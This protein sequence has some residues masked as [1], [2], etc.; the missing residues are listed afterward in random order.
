M[1]FPPTALQPPVGQGLLIIQA[2]RSHSDTPHSVVLLWTSDQPVAETSLPDDT[3]HSQEADIHA[4]SGVRI[5]N[6]IK[7]T[8]A[9]PRLRGRSHWDAYLV[10]LI[11]AKQLIKMP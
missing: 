9:D 2:S 10:S 11:K 7:P 4:P 1:F 8:A 3:Q 5:R 6:P